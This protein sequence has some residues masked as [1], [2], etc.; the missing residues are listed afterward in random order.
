MYLISNLMS[1]LNF[2]VCVCLWLCVCMWV[3]V[4]GCL[5]LVLKYK[6]HILK[7]Q[8]AKANFKGKIEWRVKKN[9]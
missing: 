2:Y 6:E 3:S 4:S 1:I 8:K 9:V 5:F 7:A